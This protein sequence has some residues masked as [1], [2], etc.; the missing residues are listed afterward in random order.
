MS[1]PYARTENTGSHFSDLHDKYNYCD[2][3]QSILISYNII[4]Q[5][6]PMV[7]LDCGAMAVLCHHSPLAEYSYCTKVSW[8]TFVIVGALE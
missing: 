7:A 8:G 1:Q 2:M 5:V 4:M 6:N 3:I